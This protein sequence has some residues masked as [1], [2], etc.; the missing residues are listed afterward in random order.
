MRVRNLTAKGFKNFSI[1]KRDEETQ[2]YLV[3]RRA[4]CTDHEE[5]SNET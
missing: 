5:I 3:E 1:T 2:S 4:G